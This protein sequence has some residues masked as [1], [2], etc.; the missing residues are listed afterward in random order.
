MKV[1]ELIASV[2]PKDK[3]K[4]LKLPV[5]EL[6]QESKGHYVAFVDEGELSHDVQLFMQASK[7]TEVVCDCANAANLCV[8]KV[9][10][11][12]AMEGNKTTS[13]TKVASITTKKKK[14]LTET[15]EVMLRMDKDAIANWLTEVFKKNK[16]LEQLFL[17]TFSTEEKQ[18]TT[19]QVQEIMEQTIKS[20]AGRR[21]TLEGANVKK[22][23]DLMAIALEPV[24]HYVTVSLNKPIGHEIFATVIETMNA[25]ERRIRTYSKKIELFYEDYVNWFALTI[26]NIQDRAVWEEVIKRA[27]Y[28]TFEHV[29]VKEVEGRTY[30]DDVIKAVYHNGAK[31]QKVFIANELVRSIKSINV[32][33][34]MFDFTYVLFLKEVAL[35]QGIYDQVQEFFTIDI[36]N[37]RF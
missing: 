19:A 27:I 9:A 7:V 11:L 25:F 33:R 28:I 13:K 6:E 1:S 32:K 2:S 10:V 23:M 36:Y 14:K 5:R 29:I 30:N 12:L 35:D 21:K 18:Y 4:A 20:V 31:E 3:N 34:N 17:L 16:P 8:H 37:N 22:L 24:N 26:N 15:E